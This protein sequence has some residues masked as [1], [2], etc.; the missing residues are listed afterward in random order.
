MAG[1]EGSQ[2][3]LGIPIH[4]S[5]EGV[6]GRE[7][8]HFCSQCLGLD[9]VRSRDDSI[10]NGPRVADGGTGTG[11]HDQ[12]SL[13]GLAGLADLVVLLVAS[14]L[15]QYF[16]G[17]VAGSKAVVLAAVVAVLVAAAAVN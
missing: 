5:C 2:G 16:V 4:S 17:A 14:I 11:N 15:L 10:H 8:V 6:V 1:V 7:L 9:Q 13:A 3:G 12:W